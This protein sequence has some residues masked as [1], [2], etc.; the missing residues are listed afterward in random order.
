LRVFQEAHRQP[1]GSA[2]LQRFPLVLSETK[3]SRQL[4]M[5]RAAAD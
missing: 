4:Q 3:G 5:L 1:N 2:W